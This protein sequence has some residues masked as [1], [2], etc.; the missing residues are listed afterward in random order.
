MVSQ[1]F[2][3]S[4]QGKH[5][6]QLRWGI[7]SAMD[8]R[9]AATKVRET[10]AYL[11][12]LADQLDATRVA[13][14]RVDGDKKIEAACDLVIEFCGNVQKALINRQTRRN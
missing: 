10:A 2:S 12:S 9:E 6:S 5:A 7:W 13:P 1:S 4:E 3:R 8:I 11:E 14:L